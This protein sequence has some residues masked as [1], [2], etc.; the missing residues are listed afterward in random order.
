MQEQCYGCAATLTVRRG[1]TNNLLQFL[2][3]FLYPYGIKGR[4]EEL[5]VEKESKRA[6]DAGAVLWDVQQHSLYAVVSLQVDGPHV[7]TGTT[8]LVFHFERFKDQDNLPVLRRLWRD[9]DGKK[10]AEKID[11]VHEFKY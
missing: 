9:G 4:K 8:L 11:E 10:V 6:M 7:V 3:I 1:R 2:Y 5:V